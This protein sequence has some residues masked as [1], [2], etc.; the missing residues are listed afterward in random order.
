MVL[1]DREMVDAV[2]ITP[3]RALERSEEGG[4]PM[5]FPTVKT[6]EAFRE[7]ESTDAVLAWYRHREIPTILPRLVRTP[8]GVAI[9]VPED[10]G[11]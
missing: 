11:S 9:E 4:L 8:T 1:D 3:A 2:W 7:F 5:V 6:L 10:G